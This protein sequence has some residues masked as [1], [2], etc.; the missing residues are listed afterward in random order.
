MRSQVII[1]MAIF[2]TSLVACDPCKNLDCK[3]SNYFGQFRIISKTDNKD[4]IFGPNKVY[5]KEQI[6]FYT[7]IGTDTTFFETMATYQPGSGF[8]SILA[9]N[10]FPAA[11]IAYMRLS[12]GDVDTLILTYQSTPSK[13][14]G[15]IT[16]INNF[17]LNNATDLGNNSRT[18]EIKK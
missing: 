17:K 6:R 9:V 8:D 1:L 15:T 2:T 4:L 12:N 13:C 5:N 11:S 3:Y 16:E 18:R 14:C 10:F 7:I